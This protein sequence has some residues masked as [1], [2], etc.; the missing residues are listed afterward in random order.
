MKYY[1][2]YLRFSTSSKEEAAQLMSADNLIGNIFT[3]EIEYNNGTYKAWLVNKF[4]KRIAYFNPSD[5][6]NIN[7]LKT[8]GLSIC[9]IL[10]FVAFT[11]HPDD[12]F[13]WGEAA[14]F[15]YESK[16]EE[17]FNLFINNIAKRLADG[18]RPDI[19]LN[20]EGIEKILNSNG[21]WSP[22]NTVSFPSKEKGTV[23]IKKRQST[24][25]KLIEQGRNKNKGCY[26]FSWIFILLI[27]FL[28]VFIAHKINLF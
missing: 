17:I 16:Y 20:G 3:I 21:N 19:N 28:V 26:L 7:L 14:L 15:A 6:Q 27:V 23:F 1:G 25:D 18:I 22:L 11:D 8:Q 24:L 2:K 12:G 4:N 5:S 13:Y 10:S 9:S